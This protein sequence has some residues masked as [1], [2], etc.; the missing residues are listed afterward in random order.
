[1]SDPTQPHRFT[2]AEYDEMGVKAMGRFIT[3]CWVTALVALG[4]SAWW[5]LALAVFWFLGASACALSANDI[6]R[7]GPRD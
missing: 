7:N 3:M 5:F 2:E 4:A 6:R 1:M